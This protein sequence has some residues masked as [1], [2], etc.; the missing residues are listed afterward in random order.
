MALSD[1]RLQRYLDDALAPE[2][3]RAVE[4]ELA[5]DAAAQQRLDHLRADAERSLGSAWRRCRASCVARAVLSQFLL[6]TLE[7]EWTDYVRF[8]TE[9]IG[10]PYCAAGLEDLARRYRDRTSEQA[11]SD[12]LFESSVGAFRDSHRPNDAGG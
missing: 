12:R 8:H 11:R 5:R 10:C 3:V 9:T 6:G 4:A 2:D 1:E 7:P